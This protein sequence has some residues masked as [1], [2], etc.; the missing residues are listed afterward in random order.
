MT[1][2]GDCG[3]TRPRNSFVPPAGPSTDRAHSVRRSQLG[4]RSA[5]GQPWTVLLSAPVRARGLWGG[6]RGRRSPCG[7]PIQATRSG[8]VAYGAVGL[9]VTSRQPQSAVGCVN[10]MTLPSAS[11][12]CVLIHRVPHKDSPGLR[13]GARPSMTTL[14]PL[15]LRAGRPQFGP[16]LDR[17]GRSWFLHQSVPP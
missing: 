3:R 17:T 14:I 10:L 12:H 15:H 9:I 8:I 7:Q 1:A 2:V 11:C 5:G 4:K 6:A 13:R 16:Q